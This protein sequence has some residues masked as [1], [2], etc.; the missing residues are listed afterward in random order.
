MENTRERI[1]AAYWDRLLIHGD[2]FSSVYA[3][4][5]EISIEEKEF[6]KFYASLEV[7]EK[8]FWK[9]TVDDVVELLEKDKDFQ[10]YETEQ[11]WLSFLYTFIEHIGQY[12]SRFLKR[13]PRKPSLCAAKRLKGAEDSLNDFV[14]RNVELSECSLR[15]EK[16]GKEISEGIH[17]AEK[18]A[19]FAH[20]CL[21]VVFFLEDESND[22][23]RTDAYIEK[24][25]KLAFQLKDNSVLDSAFDL[26]KFLRR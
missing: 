6:Y 18:K 14:D 11:K 12:R 5:K 23:E 4:C 21:V 26:L 3:L 13:F 9:Q 7:I 17:C 2:Q 22:F 19:F 15:S 10:E 20:F 1:E 8:H 25:G 24:T 16:V